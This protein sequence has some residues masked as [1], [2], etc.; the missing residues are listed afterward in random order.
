M[1]DAEL[2]ERLEALEEKFSRDV[3]V[4]LWFRNSERR[5]TIR[6]AIDRLRQSP[7]RGQEP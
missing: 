1:T 6:A 3:Q 4:Y 5:E 7:S 2:I